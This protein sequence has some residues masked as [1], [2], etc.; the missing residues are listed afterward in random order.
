MRR[1]VIPIF[2]FLFLFSCATIQ[3]GV[4]ELGKLDPREMS[5]KDLAIF[6]LGIW[7][8]EY[9]RHNVRTAI[10]DLTEKEKVELRKIKKL[11]IKSKPF[12][13]QLASAADGDLTVDAIVE[14]EVITFVE[15]FMR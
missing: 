13:D 4:K 11:L 14:E 7:N 6:A 15:S 12:I 3:Y 1:I 2:L 8:K 10:P 9:D 5:A